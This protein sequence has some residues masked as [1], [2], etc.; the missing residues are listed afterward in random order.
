VMQ[1]KNL[2]KDLVVSFSSTIPSQWLKLKS[3]L[4]SMEGA[5]HATCWPTSS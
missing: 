3:H 1:D 4:T 2:S 5:S